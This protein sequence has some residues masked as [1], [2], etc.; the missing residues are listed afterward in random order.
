[1]LA[2]ALEHLVRGIVDSPDDVTVRSRNTRRGE[3][4]E[5]SGESRRSRARHW[6][7]WAH[8]EGA[9]ISYWRTVR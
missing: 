9:S 3:L 8:S 5:G 2:E 6:T 1:M 4:L 7:Q